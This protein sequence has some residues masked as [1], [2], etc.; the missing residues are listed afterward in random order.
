MTWGVRVLHIIG[1]LQCGGAEALLFRLVTR[2]SKIEHEVIVLAGRDWYSPLLESRGI[3]VRHLNI[4]SLRSAA[5]A[6]PKLNRLIDRSRPD[7]IQGWMYKSNIIA[8]LMARRRLIPVVWGI[9]TSTFEG[10]GLTS[11]IAA[12][13]GGRYASKLADFVINCSTRSAEIHSRFG[14]SRASTE[15][16]HNGYDAA[17]FF[18]DH[19]LRQRTRAALGLDAG[20]FAIG[21][22]ARWNSQKDIPNLISAIGR[23]KETGLP[24]KYIFVGRGLDEENN[25][26][27]DRLRQANCHELVSLLGERADVADLARAMDLHVLPSCG[28]EAFPNAVAESMLSGTPN[29]VTDVGDAAA[30]V[31]ST[32]WVVEPRDSAALAAV[33]EC[34]FRE[35]DG[36]NDR[37][38]QRRNAARQRIGDNFTFEKMAEAYEDVWRRAKQSALTGLSATRQ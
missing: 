28:G 33:I 14:Y 36:G 35:Y 7:V 38:Q 37:W 30:M 4:G 3:Q 12:R 6:L 21:T 1:G 26:L 2:K 15:I 11:R 22:I 10:T 17:M 27:V 25:E 16:I 23:A 31:G 19:E 29:I 24:F 9:H 32:G 18:P 13:V 5:L 8:G 34:A 20:S